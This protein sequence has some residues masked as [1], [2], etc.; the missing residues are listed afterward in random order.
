LK[1]NKKPQIILNYFKTKRKITFK[2]Q[3]NSLT[4]LEKTK[5]EI[6]TILIVQALVLNLK[7]RFAYEENA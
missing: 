6:Y 4:A 5:R 3:K 1:F 7:R 2:S